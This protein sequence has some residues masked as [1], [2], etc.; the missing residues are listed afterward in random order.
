[1]E[2]CGGRIHRDGQE[3]PVTAYY[4]VADA[5]SDPIVADILGVK[6][7]QIEGARDPDAEDLERLE[8]DPNHIKRLAEAYL[9]QRQEKAA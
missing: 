3:E 6:R 7:S 8:V 2:Q 4:L 1:M 5:G 9:A